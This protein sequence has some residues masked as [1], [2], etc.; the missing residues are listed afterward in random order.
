MEGFSLPMEPIKDWY[1][2][3]FGGRSGELNPNQ[4][5]INKHNLDNTRLTPYLDK[6]FIKSLEGKK[7]VPLYTRKCFE[8]VP[9]DRDMP[10]ALS[11]SPRG[12]AVLPEEPTIIKRPKYLDLVKK[13]PI[14][15]NNVLSRV[16]RNPG[17][18]SK[19]L[20]ANYTLKNRISLDSRVT[21][22]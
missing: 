9:V 20:A 10:N 4:I 17:E 7:I 21:R 15:L 19:L 5:G 6:V 3:L 14:I 22:T 8:V 2:T 11:K 16:L 13:E 1:V 18:W 12:E